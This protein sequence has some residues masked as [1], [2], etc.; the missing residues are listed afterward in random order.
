MRKTAMLLFV[1]SMIMGLAGCGTKSIDANLSQSME[2]IA[3]VIDMPEGMTDL[4]ANDLKALYG[5]NSTEIKQFSGKINSVGIN[6]D[7]FIMLEAVNKDAAKSIL[8]KVQQRYQTKLNEMK[9]YLP[10]EYDKIIACDVLS[11]GNYVAML[12]CG[13]PEKAKAVYEGGFK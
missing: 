7:E 2:Q 5:I 3:D 12:V 9:D 11:S 8:E 10:A 4:T 13:D 6:G 1:L